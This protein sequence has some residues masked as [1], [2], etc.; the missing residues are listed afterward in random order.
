MVTAKWV[1]DPKVGPAKS[2]LN[3]LFDLI[4]VD[5]AVSKEV[6]GYL[7]AVAI[8]DGIVEGKS[9]GTAIGWDHCASCTDLVIKASEPTIFSDKSA[10]V[11]EG[12]ISKEV[13]DTTRDYKSNLSF[14]A[15]VEGCS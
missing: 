13:N 15:D 10:A 9:A 4:T 6:I 12:I 7:I 1:K 5:A 8:D 2:D 3:A 11:K 14:T